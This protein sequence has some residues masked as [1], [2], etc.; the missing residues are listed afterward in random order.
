MSKTIRSLDFNVPGLKTVSEM[1]DRSHWAVK[2][3]RKQ[4]QQE[5]VAVAM[6]N[7]LKGRKVELPCTVKL[8]RVGPKPLDVDNLAG[9]Q[10]H[11]Q[12]QVARQLGVDDGDTSKVSWEY[13][14]TPIRIREYAVRISIN[15][16]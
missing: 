7:A 12:D 9:S 4:G 2:N 14:Q 3:R 1:N 5:L 11:V 16:C 6:Y 10:K 13:A 15:S 8:T